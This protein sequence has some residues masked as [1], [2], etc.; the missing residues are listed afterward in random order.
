MEKFKDYLGAGYPIL[1]VHTPEEIRAIGAMVQDLKTMEEPKRTGYWWDLGRGWCELSVPAKGTNLVIKS[2]ADEMP[3]PSKVMAKFGTMAEGSVL[4]LPDFHIFLHSKMPGLCRSVKN[5]APDLKSHGKAIVI[6]SP[7]ISIP[8]ELEKDITVM[9]FPLPT[10]EELQEMAS[11][12]IQ[13]NADISRKVK[14]SKSSML[15]GRGLTINEAEN[16]VALSLCK[17]SDISKKIL[18]DEK[19]QA[20]RKTGLMEIWEPV[21]ISQLGGLDNLKQYIK[22]RESG[23]SD[24]DKPAPKGIILLGLPG[25][26]KSLSAKVIS[27]VLGFPLI[28]LD[29]G[30][31]KGS[32]VGESE[33]KMKRALATI[34]AISPCVILLD[35]VEKALGGVQSSNRTD[36]GTTSNMFS[37]LLTWMQESKQRRYLVATCNDIGDLKAISQGAF[38]RRFD[39]VFW[40]DMPNVDERIAILKIMNKRYGTEIPEGK[41]GVMDNWTGAE[42]EKFV[43][44]SIYDGEDE[45]FANVKPVYMQNQASITEARNWAKQNAR[46]ANEETKET[47]RAR[48]V[49]S[50]KPAAAETA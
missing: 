35:E 39:A 37:Q 26:G 21:D 34:D 18:E 33:A 36:G 48:H 5:L 1:W 49:N 23:F 17:T 50:A 45:A 42:I 24:L 19:L 46:W 25:A 44:D 40:V 14:I 16:A 13:G 12:L 41:A 3:D 7:V 31:L 27:S 43:V 38:L 6:V 28:R 9:D 22:R 8:V 10:V 2:K 32:L 11:N 30:S 20:I 4:F 29:I 15:P 47:K